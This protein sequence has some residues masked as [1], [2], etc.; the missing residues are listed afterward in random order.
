MLCLPMSLASSDDSAGLR[1]P[2]LL[3]LGLLAIG[4]MVPVTMPVPVLRGLVQERFQV[5]VF[6]TS[7][8][9]S[10]NMLGAMLSAPLAG[11]IADRLG[12]RK[13]LL[14]IALIL[15]ALFLFALTLPA[16]FWAFL[17]IRF[18][19]GCA[20]I[21]ALSLI[22]S[23]AASLA[24]T[25]GSGRS[26][27]IVGAGLTLGVAIGAPIGGILG[28]NDPLQPLVVGAGISLLLALISYLL[29][30]GAATSSSV[31]PRLADIFATA[32]RETALVLPYAYAFVDR[33]TVGFFTTT[34][35]L[36]MREV[37]DL[38][39]ERIGL[40]LGLFLG[41]FSLLS[42]VFG[43]LSDRVSRTGL[44]AGG[45]LIYGLGV[46][47]LGLWHPDQY[48]WVMLCLGV[49]A[50]VMFV[51]SLILTT[52]LAGPEIRSTALGGFNAAGSLGFILGPLV[53]GAVSQLVA[54]QSD[55]QTGYATAF[56]IAGFSQLLCVALTWKGMRRLAELGRST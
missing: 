18:L 30:G 9:M 41:P 25:A 43:R 27:G 10:V 49:A 12:R 4:I 42:Y 36:W 39:V 13:L 53:G 19:E 22:L 16:P 23:M 45:S 2:S 32:R 50:A 52:D 3:L 37:H 44:L 48:P 29:L 1:R 31:R 11:A 7:V 6:W 35:T 34:F 54:A 20:H 33:F 47:S 38:P 14:V 40:L 24:Q 15:D 56:A 17:L 5:S 46:M 51:P 21:T 28:Q 55:W 8:F 26:M